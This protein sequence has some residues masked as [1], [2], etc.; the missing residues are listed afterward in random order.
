MALFRDQLPEQYATSQATAA[1]LVLREVEV[2][3]HLCGSAGQRIVVISENKLIESRFLEV[4]E[5]PLGMVDGNS[6]VS[7]IVIGL[8]LGA[9]DDVAGLRIAVLRAIS[10]GIRGGPAG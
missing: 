6:Q 1:S 10:P 9:G 4:Y 5:A 8:R 3:R 7:R 2:E